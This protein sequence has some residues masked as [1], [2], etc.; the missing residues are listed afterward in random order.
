[1][2][3]F[4]SAAL[5]AALVMF[6]VPANAHVTANPNQGA[7]NS[8]FQTSL[9]IGHGC[10]GSPTVAVRVKL[11][12]GISSV[13]PQMKAGWAIE[14]KMRKLDKPVDAGHGRMVSEVVD[15]VIWRGGSLP[16]AYYD[17][18]GLVVRLPEKAGTTL[19]FPV[20]QE[21]QQ[22]AHRWIEIPQGSQKWGDLREPAPFV[23]V[24]EP[25]R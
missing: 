6:A 4:V 23:T 12:D 7:A 3:N 20:V 8:Y 19:Y 25:T 17:D 10:S 16:D 13:R 1:M 5:M 11:P 22:G 9:R 2:R 18:F 24:I 21:C 15:E 14:I